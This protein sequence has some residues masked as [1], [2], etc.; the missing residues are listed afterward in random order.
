MGYFTEDYDNLSTLKKINVLESEL[1]AQYTKKNEEEQNSQLI[2]EAGDN[3]LS[4]IYD[5][6]KN[7]FTEDNAILFKSPMK[8]F[9]N[10]FYKVVENDGLKNIEKVYV[11]MPA[12]GSTMTPIVTDDN[13][14]DFM[15]PWTED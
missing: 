5:G 10:A 7:V 8:C 9:A 14:D 6:V 15:E 3:A 12:Q 1:N 11:C 13:F 2:I 4:S